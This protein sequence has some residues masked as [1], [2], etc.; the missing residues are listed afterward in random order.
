LDHKSNEGAYLVYCGRLCEF[1]VI[2]RNGALDSVNVRVA[3]EELLSRSLVVASCL[4]CVLSARLREWGI[5][6]A[7]FV[8]GVVALRCFR[9]Y[10]AKST[11]EK[12]QMFLALYREDKR[13]NKRD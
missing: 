2:C 1:V 5:L 4:L 6:S 13:R 10:R 8:V 7:F 11:R 12:F 3:G 9:H